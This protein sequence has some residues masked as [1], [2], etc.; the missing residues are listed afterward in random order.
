MALT[1]LVLIP[2][3]GGLAA[4]ALAGR[5]NGERW[6]SILTMAATLA[7]AVATALR[8]PADAR[9]YAQVAIPWMPTLGVSVRLA[10]D[11][12]SATMIVLAAA[13]GIISVM[14]SWREIDRGSG[15]FHL[16]VCWTVASAVGVFLSFDLLVFAFFWEAMLIPSFMIIALWGHG[17]RQAAALKFLIFNAVGGLGLIAGGFALAS[18]SDPIS[19]NAFDLA[20]LHPSAT[21][22][23]WMLLGFATAFLVKLPAPPLH[24]WL[25]DAH[26][27]APTAG[28]ILLAGLLLKTGAYGLLRFPTMLF[29]QAA[30]ILAPWGV[31]L[32]AAGALYAGLVACAQQDAKRLVAYTS[33]S[34]MGVVLMGICAG[35]RLALDGAGV[36]MVAHSF[37]A[38]ALFLLIGAL[39]ERTGTR[40][41]R[42]MG[43]LQVLAP[44]FAAAFALF[45]AAALAMPGTANFVGEVLVVAGLFRLN[46]LPAIIALSTLVISVVYATRLLKGI[47]FG[48]TRL[49]AAVR[50]LGWR[51][52]VPTGLLAAGTVVVGIFPQPLV[53]LFEP[54]IRAVMAGAGR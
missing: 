24:A 4:F 48:E 34:H 1:L 52:I 45:F 12:L 8:A 19:F 31:A 7:V 41:L 36:E 9:W 11:G 30:E 42:E 54:A 33:I 50:D 38:S 49:K 18:M 16:C 37:S 51:E 29:P 14:A 46:W 44:R 53:A 3:F 23:V 32:G 27:Q 17:D 20:K 6:V 35:G 5:A 13:L 25:P 40:D 15:L 28:S 10:M 47:V 21:A 2:F 26:T 22:Q 39:Y 43:G